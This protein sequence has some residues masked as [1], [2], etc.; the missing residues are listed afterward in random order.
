[1]RDTHSPPLTVERSDSDCCVASFGAASIFIWRGQY[2]VEQVDFCR[3]LHRRSFACYPR[4][5]AGIHVVEESASL[6]P[7]DAVKAV[8]QL[9]RDIAHE[10]TCVGIATLGQG[11]MASAMQSVTLNV[12]SMANKIPLK[13][14]RDIPTLAS[15]I[16]QKSN[17]PPAIETIIEA[18]DTTR[19]S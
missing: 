15:W 9:M 3:E 11:F 18:I 19:R 5:V 12:F 1:M 7:G 8:R 4:G 17:D 14:F 16:Q 10:T 2:T 6:P 13:N